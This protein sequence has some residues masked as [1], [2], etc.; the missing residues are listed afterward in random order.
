MFFFRTKENAQRKYIDLIKEAA[1][2]W[3]NWDPP[4]NIR[5]S[6]VAPCSVSFRSSVSPLHFPPPRQKQP[7]D[8]GTVNKKTGGLNVEGN[9]YSHPDIAPIANKYLPIAGAVVDHYQIN[10]FEVRVSDVTSSVGA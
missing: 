4:R 6:I 7:G 1:A 9:I 2:K 5:V 10:S 8:F 3:P